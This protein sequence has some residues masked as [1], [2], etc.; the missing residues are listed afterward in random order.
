MVPRESAHLLNFIVY[1]LERHVF[2][3]KVNQQFE[4]E[5]RKGL[6]ILKARR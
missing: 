5:K 6:L 4:A 2:Y 3:E 1:S